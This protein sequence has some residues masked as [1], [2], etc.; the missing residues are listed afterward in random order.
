LHLII[1]ELEDVRAAAVIVLLV[2][3]CVPRVDAVEHVVGRRR[4]GGVLREH[5]RVVLQ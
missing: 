2:R 1:D 4:S 3:A 5:L